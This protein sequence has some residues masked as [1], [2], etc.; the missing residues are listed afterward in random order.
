MPD[1]GFNV[2]PISQ[3][4]GGMEFYK[5]VHCLLRWCECRN[6]LQ[7]KSSWREIEIGNYLEVCNQLFPPEICPDIISYMGVIPKDPVETVSYVASLAHSVDNCHGLLSHD[8]V[9]GFWNRK[10]V[11][12]R[13]GTVVAKTDLKDA[14]T[15]L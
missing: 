7:L 13:I 15:S 3:V 2:S 5:I 11:K 4:E 12:Y 9:V 10:V 8:I 14:L 1:H 6:P